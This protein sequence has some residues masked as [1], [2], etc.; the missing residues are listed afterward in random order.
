[1]SAI[2]WFWPNRFALGKVGIIAGLPD[3]GKG[4]LL[5]YMIAK[6]TGSDPEWPCG[7]GRAP[8]GNVVLLTA[9]DDIS[10]T[11]A[12]RLEAAGADRG[13]VEIIHMVRDKDKDRMF[14]LVS[15]LELLRQ[16]II[17]IGNVILVLIDP[18]SAYLGVGKIDSFRTTDV[19][20]VLGP[21]VALAT[22]MAVA[23]IGIMHFNKKVDVTNALLRISDSL[24]FGAIARHVYAVIDDE[25]NERKLFVKGKNN[26]A[27]KQAEAL[28]FNFGAREVGRD[29]K[30]GENIMAPYVIWYPQHV[31][32]TAT[33]AMHAA[34]ESKSPAAR[35]GAKNF[36][37][38]MLRS[39]PVPIKELEEAAKANFI[40]RATLRRA[41][42][43]LK[44][45][46]EKTGLKEG[47]TWKL[48]P[49]HNWHDDF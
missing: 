15:D 43:E 3:E 45:I 31:D 17:E 22:E 44:I 8:Q 28:A 32:V 24:A 23:V 34:N 10:D 48:P 29:R 33:E 11:V 1:M 37:A 26:L 4:Q 6:A 13:R 25:E 21:V 42:D 27:P 36:L 5:C 9:E 2:Q 40:S 41:K 12:P 46:A 7:E 14:S 38:N 20:A 19:R 18:I 47:W 39:G 16:K 35:D 49:T 30:T